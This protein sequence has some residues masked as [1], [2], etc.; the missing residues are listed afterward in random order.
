MKLDS[1]IFDS[2]RLKP[3]AERLMREACPACQ[4]QGCE[5]PGPYPAPKGRGREN[6]YLHFCLDH[7]RA[8]NKGYNYFDGMSDDDVA[9]YQKADLTGQRP[10][11]FMGA[12]RF[13][14]MPN[15]KARRGMFRADLHTDDPFGLFGEREPAAET[16]ETP[17]QRPPL[18]T[19]ER[20]ALRG[21]D[22]A[23]DFT[24]ENIK[25]RFKELVKLHHPDA[26]GGDRASEDRL[27]D[28]IQAYS[29]LRKAGLA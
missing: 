21:L 5:Q 3:D 12:N 13:A 29:Y 2:I 11:W 24:K 20:R 15:M 4:W 14:R 18:R 8:Y 1:R 6:E 22:L 27:R 10:T 19:L 28:V 7:V 25:A 26:N 17:R 23:E 16:S 9:A